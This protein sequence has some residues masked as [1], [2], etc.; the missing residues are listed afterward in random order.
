[1]QLGIRSQ[2]YLVRFGLLGEPQGFADQVAGFVRDEE[3][4]EEQRESQSEMHVR[5]DAFPVHHVV[6]RHASGQRDVAVEDH[7]EHR[8]SH[9]HSDVRAR[10]LRPVQE[11]REPYRD[12][13]KHVV[14]QADEELLHHRWLVRVAQDALHVG[15]GHQRPVEDEYHELHR[16][17]QLEDHR[18]GRSQQAGR[19][20]GG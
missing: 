5:R 1:V 7:V 4:G 3:A 9:Y 18:V 6:D 19:H 17:G 20:F 11:Q 10:E 12:R 8:E 16:N 15:V 13:A 14:V 2:D